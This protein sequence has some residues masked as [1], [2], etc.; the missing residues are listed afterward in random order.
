MLFLEI[1]LGVNRADVKVIGSKVLS[2]TVVDSTNAYLQR[3]LTSGILREGLVVNAKQQTNGKG[4]KG[5]QWFSLMGQNILMSV[6]LYPAF[7]EPDKQFYLSMAMA[8]GATDF[9]QELLPG[10][11]VQIKWPND[12]LVEGKKVGG[13]LIENSIQGNVL[14]NSIVGIGMN[15]Q[16]SPPENTNW[17]ACALADFAH[18]QEPGEL[19]PGLC[20]ALDKQYELLKKGEYAAI[21]KVYL[22][23]LYGLGDKRVFNDMQQHR[24]FKGTIVGVDEFGRL[25]VE[26]EKGV[27]EYSLK[28]IGFVS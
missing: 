28:E 27:K 4:Q 6:L 10:K 11:K 21:K 8:L 1:Q 3:E 23:H 24:P 7:L 25:Q 5:T 20:T 19:L 17:P 14:K 26:Q 9:V 22:A 2:L 16:W 13:I 15:V 18:V 12:I